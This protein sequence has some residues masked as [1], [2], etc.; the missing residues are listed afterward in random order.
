MLY[1]FILFF[2]LDGVQISED[3]I[4]NKQARKIS[5]FFSFSIISIGNIKDKILIHL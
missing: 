2:F 3:N 1:F 5:F 4:W